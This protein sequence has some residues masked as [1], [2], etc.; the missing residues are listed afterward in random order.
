[1]TGIPYIR[2]SD[3]NARISATIDTAFG[4]QRFWI[5]ADVT[6]HNFR[7]ARNYHSFD[8]VEKAAESNGIIART[9]A[10]AWGAGAARIRYF[11]QFT[12]QTFTDNIQVLIL[13]AVSFHSVYG[14]SLQLIDLDTSFTLGQLEQQRQ[15]TLAR[16]VASNS[17]IKKSGERYISL[18]N[19]LSL[20]P[21]IQRL[22]IL[23]SKT[24]AGAEDFRHTLQH[25][26]FGYRFEIDDYPTTVQGDHNASAFLA[27]LIDVFQSGKAYDAVVIVRGGGA[28]TDFLMFDNYQIGRAVAKFPIPLITGIGH[29]KNETVTD[30]MAHTPTKTPTKAAEFIIAHNRSFEEQLLLLQKSIVIRGQQHLSAGFQ[31]ISVLN[32]VLLDHI[33]A[34]LSTK[35]E[36]LHQLHFGISKLGTRQL[37][38]Q[39][40]RL[41][42]LTGKINGRA[43]SSIVSRTAELKIIANNVH[44][45]RVLFLLSKS[46]DLEYL[47]SLF[48][49]IA[50]EN[51][52][53]RGFALVRSGGRILPDV[54][55]VRRGDEIEILIG[56]TRLI[57]TV[58]DKSQYDGREFDL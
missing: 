41:Q 5:V 25:N 30:L 51:L 55:E 2:L 27:R 49:L 7:E 39:S 28:Q 22:A 52:L 18:N 20:P 44:T 4:G 9:A 37:Y 10:K 56:G 57:S 15:A 23:S 29:Q 24:S 3:L 26:A 8:L 6:S 46:K 12:G 36:G 32:N 35:K 50:P 47:S 53:K 54:K 33:R 17:F 19:Q 43:R 21:V 16:L 11:E 40:H 31:D 42:D 34:A 48:R 58:K 45:H 38:M 13:V 1:M 14:L